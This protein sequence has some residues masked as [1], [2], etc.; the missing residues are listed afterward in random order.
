[1][2]FT[3]ERTA[4]N[5]LV[6]TLHDMAYGIWDAEGR[7]IAIPE[8]FPPRLISSSFPIRRVKEKFA[9]KIKP[10]DVYLTNSPKDGAIHLPDWTFIRPIFY[11]DELLFFTCMGT[12]VADSG[13]A[14]AGSHFLAYDSIA[15]GLE[16]PARSRSTKTVTTARTWWIWCWRTTG[17]PT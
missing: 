9:G 13:G 17:C 2:R 14:Q 1:M 16:H 10:G 3:A 7:A 15:E 11:K 4:T 8:G 12:H 5:V 6:V